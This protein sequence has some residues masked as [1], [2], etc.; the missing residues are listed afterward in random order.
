MTFLSLGQENSNQI[1]LYYS[2]QGRGRPVVL[3]HGWPLASEC[4]EKQTTVLRAAGH[5]VICVD[6]RG[7]GQS[8]RTTVGLDCD[9]FAEDL[10]YLLTKL[11]LEDVMLVGFGTGCG[12]VL[13]YLGN[14]GAERVYRAA[15]I[16]AMPAELPGPSQATEPWNSLLVQEFT[17][18][19]PALLRRFLETAFNFD[20]LRGTRISDSALEAHW[21]LAL[22]AS[23]GCDHAALAAWQT[24]FR[25]DLRRV[26]L[27]VLVL[28]GE[29]DRLHPAER[30]HREVAQALADAVWSCVEGAPHGLLWTHAMEVNERLIAF[31]ASSAA[32]R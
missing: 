21:R 27:P 26:D 20:A 31:L 12:D 19:R 6:R 28:H 24:D 17:A 7:Y 9:T 15:L 22:D 25:D 1:D 3:L 18:D 10:R 30:V 13:R 23:D 14:Y 29:L 8:S 32:S 4:W 16:S 2:D 11:D 5:R